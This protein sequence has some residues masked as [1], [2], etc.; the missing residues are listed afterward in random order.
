MVF[1][2]HLLG[3]VRVF[4]LVSRV[5]LLSTGCFQCFL[6][7][8]LGIL[9]GCQVLLECSNCCQ[10]LLWCSNCCQPLLWCSNSLVEI[11]IWVF[12]PVITCYYVLLWCSN[13]CQVLLGC[14]ISLLGIVW[15]FCLV[16]VVL[17]S[18]V[19]AV[20]MHYQGVLTVARYRQ[21]V[22]TAC[23]ELL[24]Y[25]VEL[26]GCQCT[27][28]RRQPGGLTDS[29]TTRQTDSYLRDSNTDKLK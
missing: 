14:S 17:Q 15:A 22:V 8:F 9:T 11:V 25:F 1:Q 16:S 24:G 18:V 27:P 13:C 21:G 20:N 28:D 6:L 12:W 4:C 29:Q 3:I 2:T 26:A 19:L 10:A 5:F 23:G 7:S